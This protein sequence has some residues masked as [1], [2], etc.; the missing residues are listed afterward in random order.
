MEADGAWKAAFDKEPRPGRARPLGTP[1]PSTGTEP[2][3]R[4]W[5]GKLPCVPSACGRTRGYAAPAQLEHPGGADQCGDQPPHTAASSIATPNGR[6]QC[7]RRKVNG[8][9]SRV[10]RDEDLNTIRIRNPEMSEDHSAAAQVN[11][12]SWA[13]SPCRPSV[14]VSATTGGVRS[15]AGSSVRCSWGHHRRWRAVGNHQTGNG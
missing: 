8:V 1:H 5:P 14:P 12:T 3:T 10:L 11:F 15:P 4:S 9:A 7:Q 13:C 6:L 2:R